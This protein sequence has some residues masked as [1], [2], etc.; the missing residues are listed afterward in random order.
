MSKQEKLWSKGKP[1]SEKIEAFTIGRDLEFDKILAKYDVIGSKAQAT[2]LAESGLISKEEGQ[3]LV[4]E[5]NGLFNEVIADDFVIPTGYEDVHSWI[6][7]RLT[8]KLGDAGKKIHTARSRNDQVLTDLHLYCKDVL[9]QLIEKT[10][11]LALLLVDQAKKFNDTII[12][13][14]TH[15]QV[16]MPSSGGMW[17]SAYAEALADDLI[18]LKSALKIADQNPLGSAAG[19]GS[20]FPIDREVTTNEMGFSQLKVNSF[21]AQLNRGKLEKNV[22]NAIASVAQTIGRFAMDVCLYN[23]QNFG[24]I[25]LPDELTTGSSIMPHKKNPDVFELIRGKC[26]LLQGVPFQVTSLMNNLPGGY[27]REYQLLKELLFPSVHDMMSI[28]EILEFAVP[29]MKLKG[30]DTKD[31][32]YKLMYTVEAVNAEVMKGKPFRD[33]YKIVGE[34]VENGSFSIENGDQNYT[35]IGSIG[36]PGFDLIIKKIKAE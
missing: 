24:F 27:H 22:T 16:A 5:L 25:T 19:Y 30:A 11:H 32:K 23:S 2:M 36:N 10:E 12:P 7:A 26:N 14:Y 21:A 35:H 34:Q 15:L 17:F 33:A 4:A 28:L 20:S 18:V 3:Q 6:E 8:D 9:S 31:E 13:G 1:L 29:Q